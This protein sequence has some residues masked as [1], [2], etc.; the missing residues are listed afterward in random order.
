MPFVQLTT[1][2]PVPDGLRGRLADA[3][4][5]ALGLPDGAVIVQH[6][7]AAAPDAGAV[8]VVRGRL[9]E[10]AAMRE[11]VARTGAL[12]CGELGIDPD[13]VFVSWPDPG[14]AATGGGALT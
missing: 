11:A 13:L 8:A 14:T 3:V 4:R 10:P 5:A 9:R 2:L 7:S 12:L 1:D 6:V